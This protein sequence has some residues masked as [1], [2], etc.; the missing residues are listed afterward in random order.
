MRK[1]IWRLW[2]KALGSKASQNNIEADSVALIRTLIFLSYFIT[3][4]III[5]GV[6]RHWN[7]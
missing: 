7:D 1:R 5:L 4:V 2:A 6:I 3:N